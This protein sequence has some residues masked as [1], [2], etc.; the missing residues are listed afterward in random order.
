ELGG[1]APTVVL[2]GSD[3]ESVGKALAWKRFW[4]A[5]QV[6]T[7]PNRIYV[8]K[9]QYD[10]LFQVII[11]YAKGLE[12]GD[13]MADSRR[14]LAV[15]PVQGQIVDVPAYSHIY[16][17]KGRPHLLTITLSIR[18]TSLDNELI[19]KSVRYHGTRGTLIRSYLDT[20]VRIPPLGTTEVIVERGDSSGGSGANFLVEWFS[21]QPVTAPIIETVMIDTHSQQGI[22][23]ARR[24]LVIKETMPR[25]LSD[26]TAEQ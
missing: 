16:H 8:N 19:L 24:G 18:N 12:V 13:G 15:D 21:N 1:N 3:I 26:T 7:A 23:F 5:G 14:H 6:C 4:N 9:A 22:S 17:G 2:P 10:D 20:P 11:E 25:D